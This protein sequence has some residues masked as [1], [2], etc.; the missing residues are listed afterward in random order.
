MPKLDKFKVRDCEQKNDNKFKP[1]R[2]SD[3]PLQLKLTNRFNPLSDEAQEDVRDE[4]VSAP[5]DCENITPKVTP[6]TDEKTDEKIKTQMTKIPPI[7]LLSPVEDCPQLINIIHD[8]IQAEPRIRKNSKST[9]TTIYVDKLEHHEKIKMLL[10]RADISFHTY[11]LKMQKLK[12]LV[13]HGLGLFDVSDIKENLELQGLKVD[14]VV[15]FKQNEE[16]TLHNPSYLVT[17]HKDAKI[18]EAFKIRAVCY[19]IVRWK[20]YRNSKMVTQCLLRRS[21]QSNDCTPQCA[22]E[23]NAWTTRKATNDS[24]GSGP[25]T[26]QDLLYV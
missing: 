11:S 8:E 14:K 21:Q 16:A 18:Q 17:L 5:M 1:Y 9:R 23:K 6:T 7:V 4:D 10:A 3:D 12:K 24:S 20:K 2:R 13:I 22:P 26:M 19:M 25:S 15:Q